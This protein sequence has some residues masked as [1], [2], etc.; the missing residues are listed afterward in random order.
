MNAIRNLALSILV[1]MP[2]VAV[3]ENYPEK[4]ISIIVNFPAGGAT[5]LAGRALGAAMSPL[6][7]QP[8][9]IENKGGAGGSIGVGAVASSASDGYN[10]GFIAV[11]ALTTLPQIRQVPYSIESLDYVCQVFDTAIYMLVPQSSRFMNAQDLVA[12]ARSN[13]GK[14][15]YA[16]VGPGSLPHMAALDFAKKANVNISHIPFQGE[17]PAVTNLLGGHVDVYF[18]TNAV[19]S[20]HNLRRLAVAATTR[21]KESPDTPTMLELGYP[22]NWS[23]KG[24]VI[25]PANMK[26]QVRDTLEDACMRATDTPAF[27]SA[28]EKLN[29]TRAYASGSDFKQNLL[30]ESG[31]N[32]VLLREAGLLKE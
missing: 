10:I 15:N 26:K 1:S 18:G 4:P 7:K 14:I 21:S 13:P 27:I 19:A 28:M 30:A 20:I 5:D 23:I 31:R 11:A 17:A 2:A 16:T 3:A 8:V 32:R 9:V 12:F 6:L 25:A 22:V 29:L 24:G